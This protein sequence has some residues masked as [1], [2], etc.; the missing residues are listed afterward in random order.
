M[1]CPARPSS[2]QPRSGRPQWPGREAKGS[3]GGPSG[4]VSVTQFLIPLLASFRPS[5]PQLHPTGSLSPM[6]GARHKFGTGQ[7]FKLAQDERKVTRCPPCRQA[8][9]PLPAVGSALRCPQL[10]T[11]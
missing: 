10:L 3:D 9:S 7:Q 4:P 11:G 2:S 1:R 6:A 5:R 8:S